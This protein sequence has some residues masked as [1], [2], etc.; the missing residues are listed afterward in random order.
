MTRSRRAVVVSLRL[1]QLDKVEDKTQIGLAAVH[2]KKTPSDEVLNELKGRKLVMFRSARVPLHLL[3]LTSSFHAQLSDGVRCEARRQVRDA[4]P[5]G[6]QRPHR[7]NGAVTGVGRQGCQALQLECAW[8]AR[9]VV[10][11]RCLLILSAYRP[12]CAFSQRCSSPSDESS[13][14]RGCVRCFEFTIWFLLL[15]QP[16]VPVKFA[17]DGV[18]SRIMRCL[19]FNSV[20]LAAS[21]K[22]RPTTSSRARSGT[23]TRSSSRSRSVAAS[24]FGVVMALIVVYFLVCSTLLVIHTT[25]SS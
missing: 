19:Q 3:G 8:H 1:V 23:S 25:P 16:T 11:S 22:C 4:A 14:R 10:S 13:V 12:R 21:P 7:G 18:R 6:V 15:A 24:L 2:S 20:V 17:R 9:R 5:R